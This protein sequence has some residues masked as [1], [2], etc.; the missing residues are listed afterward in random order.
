M[1]RRSP[2]ILVRITLATMAAGEADPCCVVLRES[3]TRKLTTFLGRGAY[4][5]LSVGAGESSKAVAR[6]RLLLMSS[7]PNIGSDVVRQHFQ[8][9]L[10]DFAKSHGPTHN[11][12][13]IVIPEA[14]Q[15]GAAED[16]WSNRD[17]DGGWDLRTIAGP[18]VLAHPA[19]ATVE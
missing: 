16:A 5:P 19:V 17:R 2:L 1:I 12:L 6:P 11:P 18:E 10:L 14:G 3:L 9:A 8:Q 13:I 4:A 7:L 15:H